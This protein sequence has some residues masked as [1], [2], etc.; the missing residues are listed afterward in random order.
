MRGKRFRY[1]RGQESGRARAP[2]NTRIYAVGDIH[3]RADLL[4]ELR[5]RIVADGES[6]PGTK[7]IIYLGDYVDR[8]FESRGVI[9]FL[10]A[11]SPGGFEQVFLKGNHDAWMLRF[12]EDWS[13]GPNWLFNG[14]DATFASYGVGLEAERMG[15]EPAHASLQRLQTGLSAALPAHHRAFLQALELYRVE[16]DYLFVHAGIRPRVPLE[17]QDPEDLLWIRDE[18]LASSTDHGKVVV[19]GHTPNYEPQVLANRIGI[20]TGACFTGVLTCL[21]LE[22]DRRRLLQTKASAE[23]PFGA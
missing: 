22:N 10:C 14:G 9:E 15:G 12:L 17:E 7:R 6:F 2:E 13:V 21:V 3:G 23:M 19:H 1:R 20:D 4:R 11:P 5:R 16:G 8:G 18:F